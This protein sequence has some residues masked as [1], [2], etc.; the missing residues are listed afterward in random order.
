MNLSL[1]LAND[2]VSGFIPFFFINVRSHILTYVLNFFIF[3]IFSINSE[4]HSIV[5]QKKHFL[6]ISIFGHIENSVA[7]SANKIYHRKATK[8]CATVKPVLIISLIETAS[9]PNV[10]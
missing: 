9:Q 2:L 6:F 5:F 3:H 1:P 10:I 7:I 4:F 8:L